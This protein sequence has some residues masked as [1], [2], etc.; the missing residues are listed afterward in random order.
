MKALL[1]RDFQAA[2]RGWRAIKSYGQPY[3]QVWKWLVSVN[4]RQLCEGPVKFFDANV[5]KV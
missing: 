5:S 2:R 3:S 1:R 4:G